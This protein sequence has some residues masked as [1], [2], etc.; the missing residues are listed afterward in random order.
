MECG[1]TASSRELGGLTIQ[2]IILCLLMAESVPPH[3]FCL[4]TI[5]F[6]LYFYHSL[7][8]YLRV[9]Q[10]I[11]SE[12]L[13]FSLLSTFKTR[14][15]QTWGKH[16]LKYVE[17]KYWRV[18]HSSVQEKQISLSPPKHLKIYFY[19][20]EGYQNRGTGKLL[21]FQFV[22]SIWD[23]SLALLYSCGPLPSLDDDAADHRYIIKVVLKKNRTS[24][25]Q[26]KL[27]VLGGSQE[28]AE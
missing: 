9:F 24:L 5:G 4:Q 8:G 2:A 19:A 10:S 26:T 6:N 25:N 12:K 7:C 21:L 28:T 18:N 1:L 16:S 23:L 3:P 13:F 15:F 17:I 14:K 27:W 22:S 20:S 11:V